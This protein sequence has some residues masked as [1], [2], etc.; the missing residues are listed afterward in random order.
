MIHN[1]YTPFW[2]TPLKWIPRSKSRASKSRPRWAAHSRIGNIWEYLPPPRGF[3]PREGSLVRMQGKLF[4][5]R[6]R[7]PVRKSEP[8]SGL[9]IFKLRP[10]QG[11][12]ILSN[13]SKANVNKL[14]GS[15]TCRCYA[16]LDQRSIGHFRVPKTLTFQNEAKG[17]TFPVLRFSL[18]IAYFTS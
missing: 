7:H 13:R 18:N 8:A 12:K 10:F 9:L 5:R 16:K 17:T 3:S 2:K 15:C 1:F 6:S 14:T 4:W 11:V